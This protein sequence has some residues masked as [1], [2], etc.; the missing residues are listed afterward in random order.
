MNE[1]NEYIS[2]LCGDFVWV[3]D[4]GRGLDRLY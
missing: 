3:F 2:Y 1:S 4:E